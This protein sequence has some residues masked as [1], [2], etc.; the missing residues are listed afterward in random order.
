[1]R[2]RDV[3]VIGAGPAGLSAAMW[4]A[5]LGLSAILFER[6]ETFGGQLAWIHNRIENHLGSRAA[7]GPEMRAQ[8]AAQI[9]DANFE[10][11]TCA[12]VANAD[13][14]R[15]LISLQNGE[16]FA[17]RAIIIATGLRRRKLNVPGERE[18]TGHGIVESGRGERE[19]LTGKTVCVIGGGDAATENALL[20]AEVCPRVSLVHRG[21]QLRERQIFRERVK[22]NPRIT[23]HCNSTVLRL[24]G[25]QRIEGVET[26]RTGSDGTTQVLT[27]ETD[28]VL[29]R[30]GYEPNSELYRDQLDTNAQGYIMVTSEMET[31][32][33]S[34]FAV[35]DIA[36]PLAPTISGA[37]GAG[38]TAAK[39]IAGRVQH[40]NN[41]NRAYAKRQKP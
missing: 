10:L 18:F 2:K 17:T 21:S 39:I 8:F 1:M 26:A 4:C 24:L 14:S 30:I 27:I 36:N 20:L 29:I 34:V 3:I 23:V 31:N 40:Q 15:K 28:G 5:E 12:E 7:N 13:L 11:Q 6:N 25:R 32:I 33:E 19:S 16:E 35:G 37:V 22:A 41:S 9:K 38:A